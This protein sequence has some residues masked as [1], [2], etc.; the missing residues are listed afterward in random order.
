MS[1]AGELPE[2]VCAP[3]CGR[4]GC[5]AE[6]AADAGCAGERG[7]ALDRVAHGGQLDGNPHNPD[8]LT[9][10]RVRLS[11]GYHRLTIARGNPLL[12][13]G[14]GG[15]A[16]LHGV[17]LTPAG[18]PDVDRLYVTPPAGWRELC[19]EAF[20]LDRG[21]C[22]AERQLRLSRRPSQALLRAGGVPPIVSSD[23]IAARTALRSA[24]C[25]PA[26]WWRCARPRFSP[27]RSRGRLQA[28]G[29]QLLRGRQSG[30]ESPPRRPRR[31]C[32]AR[33]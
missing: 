5:V 6:G 4:L 2:R 25:E 1:G 26:A 30:R 14:E 18:A 13:P 24:R 32:M 22:P 27:A 20:G 15:W 8:A 3:P 33:R 23:S 17:F 11:A 19:R 29:A 28:R 7:R 10:L 16:I 21:R 9:P 31:G 12:A